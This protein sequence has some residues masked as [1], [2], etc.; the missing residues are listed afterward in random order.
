MSPKVRL[1]L[2]GAGVWGINYIK[3][4]EQIEG[5]IL[6]KVVC[7]NPQNKKELLQKY[8]VT[9]NWLELSKSK[10][11]DG[12]IIATPPSTHFDIAV[13]FIKNNK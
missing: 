4:I 7:R 1:G 6:K 5:V 11:I 13:E 9:N 8:E 2:V 12:V 10:A 3:T